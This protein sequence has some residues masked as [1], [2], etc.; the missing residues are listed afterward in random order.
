MLYYRNVTGRTSKTIYLH[1]DSVITVFWLLQSI[2]QPIISLY[3][4]L[5]TQWMLRHVEDQNATDGLKYLH[6]ICFAIDLVNSSQCCGRETGI[7]VKDQMLFNCPLG[8]SRH[9]IVQLTPF[10]CYYRQ[11]SLF[12]SPMVL[13]HQRAKSAKRTPI[14]KLY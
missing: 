7:N 8:N 11:L 3:T 5:R 6:F 10:S 12:A 4:A 13:K 1:N 14:P 2:L 9:H